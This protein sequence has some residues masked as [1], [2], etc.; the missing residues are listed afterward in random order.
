MR[1]LI[2]EEAEKKKSRKAVK[3]GRRGGY[4]KGAMRSEESEERK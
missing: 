2:S 3:T 1:I 4:K